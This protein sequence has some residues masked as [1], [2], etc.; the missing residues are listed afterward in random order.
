MAVHG[1]WIEQALDGWFAGKTFKA[2][3]VTTAY[4]DD[5]DVGYRSGIANEVSGAGYTAGGI[6]VPTPTATYD[7]ATNQVGVTLPDLD[8]GVLTLADLGGL[9]LY[10]DTGNAATDV[11]VAVDVFE[12]ERQVEVTGAPF[13][14]APHPDGLVVATIGAA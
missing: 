4:T 2:L 10:Q 5:P 11:V 9:V 14:Y 7:T 6:A 1:P 12:P 3:L 13:T 8:F